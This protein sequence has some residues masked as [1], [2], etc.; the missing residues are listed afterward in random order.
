MPNDIDPIIAPK[1]LVLLTEAFENVRGYFLSPNTTFFETLETLDHIKASRTMRDSD[2]TIVGHIKHVILALRYSQDFLIG[3]DVSQY[4]WKASWSDAVDSE[5]WSSLKDELR[6]EYAR[7]C[8]FVRNRDGWT[9]GN[10]LDVMIGT[11]AH[12]AYHLAIIRQNL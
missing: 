12:C 1:I 8:E 10:N 3:K 11:I 2:E 6:A 9:V 7:I 4:D 5:G